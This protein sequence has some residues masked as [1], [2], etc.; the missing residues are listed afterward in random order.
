MG[1]TAADQRTDVP[2]QRA[3]PGSEWGWMLRVVALVV[4][5]AIVAW[6]RS[7]QVDVPFKDPHG[8]LFRAKLPDTAEFL[9]VAVVIDV[10]VRWLRGRRGGATLWSTVRT[11]W[12]PYRVAMILAGLVA[13]FVVYLCYRNLKSWD[14]FNNPQDAMLLRWDR[15]LFF[16]HSPAV[17][18]HDLLGRD[19][20]AR[21]LT[22][23]YESFSWLVT[24]A[25]VAALAF[26]P[27]VRQAFVFVTAAMWAW[28]LGVGS[29]YLIPSLGP[30][31][32]APEEFAGLTRTSIQTTQDAYLAQRDHLLAHPYA[33]DAFAQISAFAS[34]HCA[35]S[36][37]VFLMARYYGLR[38]VSW[39]AG[40]FLLGTLIATVYLGWHFA[41]DDLAGLAIAAAAW[42]LGPRTVGARR[43][44]C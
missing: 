35:L 5:F 17:L 28:I 33:S 6:A 40:L 32:A 34:L 36:C 25:L 41:V 42:W 37:L 20:A 23:L 12:T 4:A 1:T 43:L 18:L 15:W 3:E 39:A 29:Y 7:R 14:V 21:L 27:T 13:Y 26:T 9:L 38:L 24:I 30:F 8:K 2:P 11:R 44:P 16:G 22:D 31:N 10:V 19:L